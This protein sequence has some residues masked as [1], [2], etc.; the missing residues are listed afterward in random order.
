MGVDLGDLA[1]KHPITLDSLSGKIIAIDSYNILYQ[2]L[3]SIRQ[4]DGRPLMDF[5][6]NITAHLSGLFYRTAKLIENGIKPVYV[7]DGKPSKLKEKTIAE[8][9]EAKKLAAQKWKE[10][11]DEGRMD[12]AKKYAQGSSKLTLEMVGECKKLLEAMG[13]PIVQAPTEG[14]AQASMM[15]QKGLA[16]A[17]GSQDYDCLLFGAPTLVR[18]LSI[19]G[20]RKVPR[21]ERFILVEP[22]EIRIKETLS[23]LGLTREQL[24]WLGLLLGTDFNDGVKGVGPKTALK[25]IKQN[26]TLEDV[27][28]YAKTKYN[29]EFEVEPNEVIDLF[30]NPKYAEV[31]PPKWNNSN[32]DAVSKLLVEDHDFSADRVQNTLVALEKIL[33][34]RGAQSKLDQWF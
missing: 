30:L 34:E 29:Y 21:Q 23:L 4:E 6:G 9:V 32:I 17:A 8:R 20:R 1:V 14:E 2:F 18:N 19:T 16:Y 27:L 33:K 31:E 12:D 5:K 11:L 25:I 13:V 3:S 26:K 7:F 28:A 10:A 15:V 24:I 22:E